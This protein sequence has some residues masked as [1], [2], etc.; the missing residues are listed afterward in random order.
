MLVIGEATA[1]RRHSQC[2]STAGSRWQRQQQ[3]QQQQ[4]C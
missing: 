4:W 2:D 1:C 3:Q